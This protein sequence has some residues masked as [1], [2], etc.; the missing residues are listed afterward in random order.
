MKN[1]IRAAIIF[2]LCS[3]FV[4]V[5]AKASVYDEEIELLA[6]VAIAEAEGESELGKRLVIDTILNRVSNDEFPD[7][8]HDV[9]YQEGQFSSAHNGRFKRCSVSDEVRDL[10][11][12]EWDSRTD[13]EVLFFNT[14]YVPGTKKLYQVDHHY[15]STLKED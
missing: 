4:S 14:C 5:D 10:V 2:L 15:F 3:C 1:S 9:V 11:R 8:V 13:P 6:T 7:N 12:E